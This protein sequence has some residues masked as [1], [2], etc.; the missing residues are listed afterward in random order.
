[1]RCWSLEIARSPN[2]ARGPDRVILPG[3]DSHAESRTESHART[4]I[5]SNRCAGN[6]PIAGFA[7]GNLMG[8]LQRDPEGR[9]RRLPAID[10]RQRLIGNR[11]AWTAASGAAESQRNH[12]AFRGRNSCRDS[13]VTH[14]SPSLHAA[15]S[16]SSCKPARGLKVRTTGRGF[17]RWLVGSWLAV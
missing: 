7:E 10:L 16:I 13:E 2:H 6:R 4:T 8:H 14:P 3:N 11:I 17:R 15:D 1:M 9:R 12:S 5:P